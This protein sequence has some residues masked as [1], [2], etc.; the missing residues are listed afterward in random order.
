MVSE[1]I[2]RRIERILDQ[3][4]EAADEKSCPASAESAREALN[5]DP[6][7]ADAPLLLESADARTAAAAADG[8]IV[9]KDVVRQLVAGKEFL[10]ADRGLSTLKGFEDPVRT[11]EVLW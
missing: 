11:W 3:A 6:S 9:V 10:F 5:L 1:R 7:N 8:Q 4:E 2:Q